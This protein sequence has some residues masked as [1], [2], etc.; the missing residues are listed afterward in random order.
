M[1]K[2][3]VYFLVIA[4]ADAWPGLMDECEASIRAVLP[5]NCVQRVP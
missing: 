3:G 1:R 4:C 5:H 2:K